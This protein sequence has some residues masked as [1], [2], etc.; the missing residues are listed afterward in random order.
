MRPGCCRV[1]QRVLPHTHVVVDRK[2]LFCQLPCPA[3]GS[4]QGSLH[5][6]LIAPMQPALL[7]REQPG[8]IFF[9]SFQ[10]SQL[11]SCGK[12]SYL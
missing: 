4:W 1:P 11:R 3:L 9:C 12:N 2:V 6:T 7:I 8:V 5:P 10:A